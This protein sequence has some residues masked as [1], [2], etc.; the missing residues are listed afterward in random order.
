MTGCPSTRIKVWRGSAPRIESVTR[1]I[2]S[3]LRVMPV[4]SKMMSSTDFACFF[5]MSSFVMIVVDCDSYFASSFAAFAST[6][7]DPV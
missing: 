4:S 1:P 5:S 3:T 7:T 6:S 2:A